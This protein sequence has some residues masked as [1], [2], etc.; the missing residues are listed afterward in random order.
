[1]TE[2]F[3]LCRWQVNAIGESRQYCGKSIV[4]D[5]PKDKPFCEGHI[6][7]LPIWPVEGSRWI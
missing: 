4:K 7:H 5:A 2:H 3:V 6:S 1:M